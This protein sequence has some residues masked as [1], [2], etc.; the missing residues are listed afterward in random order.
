VKKCATAIACLTLLTTV[1]ATAPAATAL[2][3]SHHA[4]AASMS[5]DSLY[6]LDITLQTADGQNIAL[7][8]LRGAPLLVTM[9][10]SHCTSV[11]P[12]LT[13]ELQG[14]YVQLT[15]LQRARIRVLMVS[16]D[17]ERDTPAELQAFKEQHSIHE[18]GWVVARASGN[19]VRALAAVLGIRYRELAD[20]SF[21]HSA[22]IALT[23][24]EGVIRLASRTPPSVLHGDCVW[25]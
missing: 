20:Q 7:S 16:F 12:M 8:S 19:D 6:Q 3:H 5:G 22:V 10:Y 14:I 23:D 21:N 13:T 2:E 11:C 1:A 17:A 24:S 15:P 25:A 4:L 18:A 9:F